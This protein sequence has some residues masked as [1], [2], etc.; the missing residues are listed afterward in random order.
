MFKQFALLV[1]A[2]ICLLLPI[3]S[4]QAE[5]KDF[6]DFRAQYRCEVVNRLERIFSFGDRAQHRDRFLS[7]TVQEHTHGYV[8]CI[9]YENGTRLLCEASSGF[10]LFKPEEPRTYRLPDQKIEE[11]LG[12][13]FSDDDRAGNFQHYSDVGSPPNFNR[14]ADFLLAVLHK[15]YDATARSNLKFNAPFARGRATTCIP[16]G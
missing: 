11:L 12:L 8:Q 1:F 6:R 4:S 15:A 16:V 3:D 2:G 5:S 9:F 14:I 10:F 13:G 7:I